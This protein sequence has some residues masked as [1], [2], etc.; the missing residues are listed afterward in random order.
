MSTNDP[1]PS[2]RRSGCERLPEEA[3]G[4]HRRVGC[5][6]SREHVTLSIVDFHLSPSPKTL[7]SPLQLEGTRDGNTLIIA[8][9]QNERVRESLHFRRKPGEDPA[10]DLNDRVNPWIAGRFCHGDERAQRV[11]EKANPVS[12]CA[13]M[14]HGKIHRVFRRFNPRRRVSVNRFVA[15]KEGPRPI[16]VTDEENDMA[17][18]RQLP[19]EAMKFPFAE[20]CSC[21]AVEHQHR[22]TPVVTRWSEHI[23]TDPPAA[24]R[25]CL[26]ALLNSRPLFGVRLQPK[27]RGTDYEQESDSKVRRHYSRGDRGGLDEWV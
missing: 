26:P 24:T 9:M 14:F 1:L 6:R 5:G 25:E 15:G 23:D 10:G 22:R 11:A 3:Q 13:G 19:G 2:K 16:K 7:G 27:E 17:L 8:P 21:R 20:Q 12:S 4:P 18:L